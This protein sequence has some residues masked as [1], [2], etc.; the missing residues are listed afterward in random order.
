MTPNFDGAS[1]EHAFLS[2]QMGVKGR[3]CLS[4]DDAVYMRTTSGPRR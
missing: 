2:M 3:I 4:E 1:F